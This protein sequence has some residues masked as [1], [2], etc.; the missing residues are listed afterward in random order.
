MELRNAVVLTVGLRAAAA[1]G[2]TVVLT[3]DGADELLGGYAYT[4][5]LDP[6]AFVAHRASLLRAATWAA[7][8][9]AAALG[10]ACA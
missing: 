6:D 9:L 1:A 2:V 4:H 3:G 10:M 8:P 7:P 5:R